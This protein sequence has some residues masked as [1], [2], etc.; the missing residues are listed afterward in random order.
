MN[1]P[2]DYQE[3]SSPETASAQLPPSAVANLPWIQIA[4]NVII[5]TILCLITK[6]EGEPIIAPITQV[7]IL[8]RLTVIAAIIAFIQFC[9]VK[10]WKR[11]RKDASHTED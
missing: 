9:C 7:S 2:N 4:I 5:S 3:P 6:G 8:L 1:T 10:G 11:G